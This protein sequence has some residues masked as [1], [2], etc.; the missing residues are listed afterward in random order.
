MTWGWTGRN[1]LMEP[2]RVL[3]A[4][5]TADRNYELKTLDRMAEKLGTGGSYVAQEKLSDYKSVADQDMYDGFRLFLKG[6]HQMVDRTAELP[7]LNLGGPRLRVDAVPW[8][9]SRHG[10]GNG[11][12][13]LM[14]LPGAHSFVTENMRNEVQ[15]NVYLHKLYTFGPQTLEEA[16]HYYKF[17]VKGAKPQTKDLLLATT[18]DDPPDAPND[19]PNAPFAGPSPNPFGGRPLRPRPEPPPPPAEEPQ[20]AEAPSEP[21]VV[22]EEDDHAPYDDEMPPP[23]PPRKTRP[24]GRRGPKTVVE[25]TVEHDEDEWQGVPYSAEAPLPPGRDVE[26]MDERDEGEPYVDEA[27]PSVRRVPR[28]VTWAGGARGLPTL[29][30][31][32]PDSGGGANEAKPYNDEPED[33]MDQLIRS[34]APQQGDEEDDQQGVPYDDAPA[35]SAY[36]FSSGGE[37]TEPRQPKAKAKAKGRVKAPVQSPAESAR[38]EWRAPKPAVDQIEQRIREL[39]PSSGA[40]VNNGNDESGVSYDDAPES[41]RPF[42]HP[43]QFSQ[44]AST[45]TPRPTLRPPPPP[46]P[47]RPYADA[48][49]N[50]TRPNAPPRRPLKDMD[51]DRDSRPFAALERSRKVRDNKI[52]AGRSALPEAVA[53]AATEPLR[54]EDYPAQAFKSAAEEAEYRQREADAVALG[55]QSREAWREEMAPPRATPR[56]TPGGKQPVRTAPVDEGT[57]SGSN[58]TPRAQGQLRAEDFPQQPFKSGADKVTFERRQAEG[59]ERAQSAKGMTLQEEL[60]ARVAAREARAE[61]G[62]SSPRTPRETPR[63]APQAQG[64]MVGE[65]QQVLEKRRARIDAPQRDSLAEQIYAERQQLFKAT[66]EYERS[67]PNKLHG[68]YPAWE[69]RGAELEKAMGDN[70]V[71]MEARLKHLD[72]PLAQHYKAEYDKLYDEHVRASRVE[73]IVSARNELHELARQQ[74]ATRPPE[75]D[76]AAD[77]EWKRN[78]LAL[79]E[80]LSSNREELFQAGPTEEEVAALNRLEKSQQERLVKAAATRAEALKG[81]EQ[82]ASGTSSFEEDE[83]DEEGEEGEEGE[84]ERKGYATDDGGAMDDVVPVAPPQ[85]RGGATMQRAQSMKGRPMTPKPGSKATMLPGM[86]KS[87]VGPPRA[88]ATGASLQ[89]HQKE[90]QNDIM[91]PMGSSAHFVVKPV[92]SSGSEHLVVKNEK[93]GLLKGSYYRATLA[94]ATT[95]PKRAVWKSARPTISYTQMIND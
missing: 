3:S 16:W 18:P 9:N 59:L 4:P 20:P 60:A 93:G 56:A 30:E 15:F 40:E 35:E 66:A 31:D 25:R 13:H 80:A 58:S 24:A 10:V 45:G 29:R 2:Q 11:K 79:D 68:E 91:Q 6:D 34:R 21:A 70:E 62:Q 32:P 47:S 75:A 36:A 74:M 26:E 65:L 5:T 33:G 84:D 67:E 95:K 22:D 50:S 90:N 51:F 81:R 39:L 53:Q 85:V 92:V 72:G 55:N 48:E 57:S 88:K 37:A 78:F 94:A 27:G 7:S 8:R 1:V 38:P 87:S 77:A 73:K 42:A 14:H 43:Y 19:A 86:F 61:S 82:R 17:I 54:A 89:L 49:I 83:E 44:R 52:A 63:Q 12:P 46:P 71:K 23:P 64:N 41:D 28:G 76:A 69:Q